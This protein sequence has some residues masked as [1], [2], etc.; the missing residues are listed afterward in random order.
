MIDFH[1]HILY[2]IDDGCK[3]IEESINILKKLERQN[4]KDI[5][6]TPHYIEN[7]DYNC[8]NEKKE[9]LLTK[10][11]NQIKIENIDINLYLGNEIYRTDS[12]IELI[13]KNEIKTINN[14]KYILIEFP[15]MNE[16]NNMKDYIY[17]LILS[18][19][20]PVIAHPERYEYFKKDYSKIEELFE[21]GAKF[22]I[23][24]G[25]I[26]GQYGKDSKKLVKKILKNRHAFI[27]GSDIHHDSNELKV[28]K[29]LNKISKITDKKYCREISELNGLEIIKNS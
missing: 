2:G 9:F 20:I 22:Q 28:K 7:S 18:G 16:D 12:I 27:I 26:V 3:T 5:V 11:K 10:L 6:L 29:I 23:N 24:I 1:T 19:Y 14:S 8:N 4:V 17:N 25:S 15:F 21:I 13:D